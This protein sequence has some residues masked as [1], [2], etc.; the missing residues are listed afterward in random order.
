MP[1]QPALEQPQ[2]VDADVEALDFLA[3]CLT[4]DMLDAGRQ[5]LGAAA[6]AVLNAVLLA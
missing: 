6:T 1:L 4:E 3:A 5:P 2:E